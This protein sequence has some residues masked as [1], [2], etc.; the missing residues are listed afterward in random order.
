MKLTHVITI[1]PNKK[2]EEASVNLSKIANG[3]YNSAL[4]ENNKRYK[5]EEK[6]SFYRGYV[7]EPKR[8]R[9]LW[10]SCIAVRVGGA[11]KGKWNEHEWRSEAMMPAQL[12]R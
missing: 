4:Y 11:P 1:N 7:Q 6:F 8:Q 12:L 2:T 5:A 9:T 3:L 10:A